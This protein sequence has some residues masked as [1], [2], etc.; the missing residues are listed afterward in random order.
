MRKC[1]TNN[2]SDEKR[3]ALAKARDQR[4]KDN[5]K[6]CVKK[7]KNSVA[8]LNVTQ[9]KRAPIMYKFDMPMNYLKIWIQHKTNSF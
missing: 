1:A 9:P 4:I 3:I 2:V 8:T 7:D 6:S 5:F